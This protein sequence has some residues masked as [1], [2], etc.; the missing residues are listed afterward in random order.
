[1]KSTTIRFA[2]RLYQE[3]ESASSTTGL[4][5]NSIVVVA[6]LEWLRENRAPV[7]FAPAQP[8]RRSYRAMAS[9]LTRLEAAPLAV[10]SGEPE[11]IFT[12]SAAEALNHATTEAERRD[13]WIGTQHLL[14]GLVTVEEGRAAQALRQ[15]GVDVDAVLKAAPA[16]EPAPI[17]E[18]RGLPTKRVRQVLKGA[19][20]ESTRVGAFQVGTDHLLLGLLLEGESPAARALEAAGATYRALR[21]AT[22][23]LAPEP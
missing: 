21:D 4:P 11:A 6:C 5:I 16:A 20:E 1:M 17:G 2:D 3:L 23:G 9:Q 10:S 18:A 15:L 13:S 8:W 22:E 7:L 12:E 14:I 19:R